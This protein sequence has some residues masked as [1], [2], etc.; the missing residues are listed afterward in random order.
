MKVLWAYFDVETGNAMHYN[1]GVGS[2][3]ACLRAAGHDTSLVY[4]RQAPTE[5]EVARTL[6]REAPDAVFFPVNTHQWMFARRYAEWV[7]RHGG[8]MTVVGG[9]HAIL[10]PESV[11]A[12]PAIDAACIGEGEHAATE[13]IDALA[14]H[15]A[16]DGIAGMWVK[17]PSGTIARTPFRPLIEDLD[18]LPVSDR[19][20]WDQTQILIDGGYELSVMGGRGCPFKCTYCANSARREIYRGHGKY[21]RMCS[22]R[23][24]IDAIAKLES[25]YAFDRLFVE[26]D[27]FIFKHRWAEEFCAR[28]KERFRYPFRAYVRVEFCTREI[29][30][31]MKDAGCYQ[32]LVGV[33]AG[34][35]TLRADVLNRKMSNA[36]IV[37]VFRWADELGLRTWNFNM[38]GFP[39]E[40]EQTIEDLF[41][42]NRELRPNKAQISLFYPYPNT[43]LHRVAVARGLITEDERPTYFEKSILSLP[44]VSRETLQEA[45]WRFR[46]MSL[47]IRAE[48][49]ALGYLDFTT[50][51]EGAAI[52]ADDPAQVRLTLLVVNGWEEIAVFQHPR[53]SVTFRAEVKPKSLFRAKL[54]LDPNCLT[55]G[56]AGVRFRLLVANGHGERE[57]LNTYLDP[58]A[59]PAL[60]HW[61]HVEVDLADFAGK[62]VSFRFVTEPSDAGDLVGA[63]SAWG[64]PHLTLGEPNPECR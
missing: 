22:P 15:G 61:H 44:T 17:R 11:I 58:K 42:L 30:R 55:W 5:D 57:V 9:I 8:A 39:D 59:D 54:A 24:L 33:E 14:G 60:R 35:E 37:R 7:K 4:Y 29:L 53:A 45:F 50:R 16:I 48:K 3:D 28:Y 63:W 34:N 64:R 13:L 62:D 25:L 49:E 12:H 18:T 26:D 52:E 2:V 51:L 43:E 41:A 1:H 20:V 32:I 19:A 56:G 6:R 21:V 38:F 31:V 46:K 23:Y 47:E 36:S 10:D 40:T 27:V